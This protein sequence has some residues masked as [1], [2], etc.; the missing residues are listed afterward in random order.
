L[1]GE[2]GV[3][4]VFFSGCPMHCVYCQN[5]SVSQECRGI[6][7]GEERLAEIFVELTAAGAVALD[8]VSATQFAPTVRNS[9]DL[10]RKSGVTIPIVWNSNGYER[11][12]TLDYMAASVDIFL[13]DLK[14]VNEEYGRKYSAV[15][16]YFQVAAAAIRRMVEIKGAVKFG[17]DGLLKSGVLV[18][19][20][21]LPGHRHDSMA[22]V[23]WLWENFGN[24]VAVSLM[25]QYIPAGQAKKIP[26]LNRKI[27]TF[28]YM[29]VV[30]HAR[31]LGFEHGYIQGKNSAAADLIP[32]FDG[33][34]VSKA[35][36]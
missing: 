29:S 12:E 20:L 21:V 31:R 2:R 1:G 17:A 24:A 28:E 3:G 30:D 10:A 19:H 8:L 13:P 9:L 4:A 36:L 34:G 26:A 32:N 27:T 14:Y 5:Y 6:E 23:S 11:I 7:I 18:R 25:R 33:S 15:A 22:A 35:N 16:D